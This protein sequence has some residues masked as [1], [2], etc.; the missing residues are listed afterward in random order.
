MPTDS[1][2]TIDGIRTRLRESG[3]PGAR[4]IAYF[5]IYSGLSE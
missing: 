1:Y 3:P 2:V 4:T 5:H